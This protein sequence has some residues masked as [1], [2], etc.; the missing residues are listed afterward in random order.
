MIIDISCDRNGGIETS[1]PTSIEKPIYEVDGIIH[2]VVDHTPS[3]FFKTVSKS[4]SKVVAQYV[5]QMIEDKIGKVLNKAL[6]IDKGIIKDNRIIKFQ[7][8]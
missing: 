8:R 7:N 3:L 2:Y 1:I 5:D 6:I 4:L